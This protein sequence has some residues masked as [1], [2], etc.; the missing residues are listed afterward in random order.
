MYFEEISKSDITPKS[1]MISKI[2]VPP[3]C[4]SKYLSNAYQCNG[5]STES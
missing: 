3:E 2:M 4:L 5:V 1:G